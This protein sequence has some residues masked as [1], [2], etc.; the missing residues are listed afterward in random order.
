MNWLESLLDPLSLSGVCYSDSALSFSQRASWLEVLSHHQK[1]DFF[2]SASIGREATL[3][4]NSTIRNDLISWLE[5]SRSVDAPILDEL[6]KWR[7]FLNQSLLLSTKSTEAH[8]AC[9]PPGHF[10]KRHKDQHSSSRSRILTF[11]VYLHETWKIGDGG[12]LVIT[13]GDSNHVDQIIE[14]LPGR[15]VIFKSDEI[16]HEVRQSNFTRSSLTG[17]FRYDAD[18]NTPPA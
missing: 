1:N 16:W 3:Q 15:V 17:W 11:V 12:E 9:Y 2:R 8:F 10:Y 6:N 4:Q 7:S 5:T 13:K 14:P 18:T